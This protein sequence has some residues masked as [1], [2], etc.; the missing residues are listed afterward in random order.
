MR[1]TVTK[2][3]HGEG[4]RAYWL[5]KPDLSTPTSAPLIAFLHGWG[6]TNP[7][8]YGA[9][10]DHLVKTG[11][12][13]VYPRYQADLR[14]PT[15]DFFP[16]TVRA[17]QDAITLLEREPGH[18]RPDLSKFAVVGHSVGGL[19]AANLAAVSS[20]S[21]LPRV[22]AV[23]SVQPGRTWNRRPVANVPLGDLRKIPSKTLML[24][25]VGDQDRLAGDIDAKRI[26]YKSKQLSPANKDFVR[27]RSDNHGRPALVANHFAPVAID[28]SYDDGDKA[29]RE[30][31]HKREARARLR[32]RL[33]DRVQE[34]ASSETDEDNLPLVDLPTSGPSQVDALDYY[35]FWKL[36]DALCDAAFS[37]RNRKF[38]LGNTLQQR[39]MGFWTDGVPVKQLLVTDNP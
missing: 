38:A 1:V 5:F 14:T 9:W 6:A 15:A 20:D 13:V 17:L 37:G 22:W 34:Q 30:S 2:A 3:R 4:A 26:Y 33:Q 24:V 11:N 39:F 16:N 29:Q 18:V 35:G 21:G 7:A 8:I 27:M 25:V 23:M 32:E 36:F 12:I 31:H 10:I 28:V 19:L